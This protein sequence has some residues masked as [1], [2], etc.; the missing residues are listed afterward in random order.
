[1]L[2]FYCSKKKEPLIPSTFPALLS[3]SDS[4]QLAILG[5]LVYSHVPPQLAISV[6]L[7]IPWFSTWEYSYTKY[8]DITPHIICRQLNIPQNILC[9]AKPHSYKLMYLESCNLWIVLPTTIFSKN[10][11][12][13]FTYSKGFYRF[14]NLMFFANWLVAFDWSNYVIHRRYVWSSRCYANWGPK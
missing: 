3:L 8:M 9:Y 11:G 7:Q 5:S 1:M 12:D 13:H 10:P 6:M 2:W 14:F 4:F